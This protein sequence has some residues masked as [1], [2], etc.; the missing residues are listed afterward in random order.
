[1]FTKET[2]FV[3]KSPL[4]ADGRVLKWDYG[5]SCTTVYFPYSGWTFR[6][7]KL[8]LNEALGNLTK[9]QNHFVSQIYLTL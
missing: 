8:Y 7:C 4:T 3:I 9:T 2:E 5:D 1:M 6:I